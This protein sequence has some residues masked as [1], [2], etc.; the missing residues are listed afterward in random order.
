M[1]GVIEIEWRKRGII[2]SVEALNTVNEKKKK[3]K[4]YLDQFFCA[5]QFA[6]Y[7]VTK[8]ERMCNGNEK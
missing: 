1:L 4:K 6:D 5:K 7:C 3:G 8:S 2:E